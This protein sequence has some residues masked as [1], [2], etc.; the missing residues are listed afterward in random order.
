MDKGAGPLWTAM[1]LKA[2]RAVAA[3]RE[4]A[5]PSGPGVYAWYEDGSPIYVGKAEDLR[6]RIWRRHLR[7]GTSMKTSALRRNMAEDLGIAP[8]EEIRRGRGLT[9]EQVAA[10]NSRLRGCSIA[11]RLCNHGSASMP[12]SIVWS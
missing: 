8:A 1:K 10:V 2:R 4:E 11:C 6:D 9:R 3:L 7:K 12:S 5:V